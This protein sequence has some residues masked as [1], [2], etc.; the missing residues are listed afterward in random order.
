M[1]CAPASGSR[2][3]IQMVFFLLSFIIAEG[4]PKEGGFRKRE[5]H[6]KKE[7]AKAF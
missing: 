3:E 6:K 1:L 2:G 4:R 7:N 5:E